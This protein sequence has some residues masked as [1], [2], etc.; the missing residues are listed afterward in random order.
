MP[1]HGRLGIEVEL[2]Q[3]S[4]AWGR[5]VAGIHAPGSGCYLGRERCW[6]IPA[7]QATLEGGGPFQHSPSSVP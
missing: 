1:L 2:G 6:G 5:Q 3:G 4:A 7:F